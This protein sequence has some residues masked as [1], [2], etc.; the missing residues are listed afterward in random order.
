MKHFFE[1]YGGVALGILAL[2]VL[3][4]M[5]TPV[6]NIIKTSLQGTVETFSSGIDNQTDNMDL[7]LQKAFIN[8][9]T[10]LS[11]VNTTYVK[12]DFSAKGNL[13]EIDGEQ[14]RVLSVYGTEVKVMM[15]GTYKIGVYS[16]TGE[17]TDFTLPDNSTK[18]GR[19]YAD[20]DIDQDMTSFYNQL[21]NEVQ[22]AIVPQNIYQSMYTFVPDRY[23]TEYTASQYMRDFTDSFPESSKGKMLKLSEVS[24][25]ERKVYALEIDDIIDYLGDEWNSN[26]LNSFLF[27]HTGPHSGYG[28]WLRSAIDDGKRY[29]AS[30]YPGN[31][32][33][34]S[35]LDENCE[36]VVTGIRPMFVIDLGKLQ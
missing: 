26:Q 28:I 27:N 6:G 5:I 2:L 1:Q 34:V 31:L 17:G 16:S 32:G 13:V 25:G 12:G 19:K 18:I 30:V 36:N 11:K 15:M 9:V 21:P 10:D 22:N 35:Y 3:I 23:G 4:A 14:Y 7:Q 33:Y 20:S 24:I 8:A 29:A